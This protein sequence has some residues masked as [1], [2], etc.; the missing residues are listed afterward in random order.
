MTES[1][2]IGNFQVPQ[3]ELVPLLAKY[4][5]LPGVLRELTIDRA[6]AAIT[7]SNDEQISALKQFYDRYQLTTE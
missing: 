1:I 7:C 3:A 5:L 2:Q 4:Q 6:I